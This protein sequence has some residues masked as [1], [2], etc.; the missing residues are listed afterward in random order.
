MRPKLAGSLFFAGGIFLL[1]Y[2]AFDNFVRTG[3]GGTVEAAQQEI[4]QGALQI[5]DKDGNPS[6][7][8]PLR[9]TNVNAEISGQ[10]ARVTLTQEFHNPL[11]EKIEAVYVFP[12]PQTAAVDDMTMM[13]GD[14]TEH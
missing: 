5:L 3:S 8:C 6:G 7:E 2:M 10:L 4:T 12:L 13:V 11:Q 1:S 14:R 9:H